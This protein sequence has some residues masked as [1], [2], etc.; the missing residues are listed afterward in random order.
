MA[1]LGNTFNPD[2]VEADEFEPIPAGD[3]LAQIIDSEIAPTKAG[4]GQMLKLTYEIMDGEL[5]NRRLWDRLNIVNPNADAQRI[6]HQQLKKLCDALGTGPIQDSEELHF[7]PVIIQVSVKQDKNGDFGPQNVIRKF[8]ALA[9]EA[10]VKPASK[11]AAQ[12]APSKPAQS[13]GRPWQ[14]RAAS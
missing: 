8:T 13:G 3:Y 14:K 12:K 7:K 9:G 10:E 6:A 2:E 5:E 11:A 1:S 4:T